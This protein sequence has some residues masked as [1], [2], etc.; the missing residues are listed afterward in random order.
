M[1]KMTY[2]DF[3][4]ATD[5]VTESIPTGNPYTYAYVVGAYE[6]MLAGIAADL[7]KHKQVELMRGLESLAKRVAELG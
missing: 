2:Q 5:K 1:A 6:T 7:P 3:R 4:T